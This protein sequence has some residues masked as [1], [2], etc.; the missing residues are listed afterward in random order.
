MPETVKD[1]LETLVET[2]DDP[3]DYPNALASGPLPSYDYVAGMEGELTVRLSDEELAEWKSLEDDPGAIEDFINETVDPELPLGIT[4][5]NKWQYKLE[6]N[7]LTLW[8]EDVEG[9]LG[10]L[11][12]D[13]DPRED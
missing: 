4:S 13:Y 3:G 6:G 7:V 1:T 11:E 12:P 9:D 8:S 10:E 2:W 5:V